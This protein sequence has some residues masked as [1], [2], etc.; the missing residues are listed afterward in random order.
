M[1]ST[2]AQTSSALFYPVF[3]GL[4][5]CPEHLKHLQNTI[6]EFIQSLLIHSAN[7]IMSVHYVLGPMVSLLICGVSETDK[8]SKTA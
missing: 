4:K 7:I 3:Q 8:G 1:S 5:L 6:V 2:S